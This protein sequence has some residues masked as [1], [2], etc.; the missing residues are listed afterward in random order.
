MS[1]QH[2]IKAKAQIFLLITAYFVPKKIKNSLIINKTI[3]INGHVILEIRELTG[4]PIQ[5]WEWCWH[6]ESM[7]NRGLEG[8]LQN[9]LFCRFL[10]SCSY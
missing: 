8:F 1:I 9:P 3:E 6:V 5:H 2:G 7:T 4:Q 10:Q